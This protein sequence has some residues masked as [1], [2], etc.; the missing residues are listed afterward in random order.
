[1]AY[2]TNS[3][4]MKENKS[5][6]NNEVGAFI[7]DLYNEAQMKVRPQQYSWLLQ[8][9]Y[10]SGDQYKT[11]DSNNFKITELSKAYGYEEREVFNK[12]RTIRNTFLARITLNKPLPWAEPKSLKDKDKKVAK[13]TNAVI[14]NAWETLEIGD[15][16]DTIGEYLTDYGSAFLKVGWDNTLGKKIVSRVDVLLD[17][18]GN[19]NYLNEDYKQKLQQGLLYKKSIYEGDVT[20]SVISPFEIYV[21]NPTRRNL[22]ES[23]W[24]LH[25]RAF[26]KEVVKKVYML[27]DSDI[28]DEITNSITLQT[29]AMSYGIGYYSG[30]YGYKT[31]QLEDVVSVKEYYE[32]PTNDF[33][34]GRM[35]ISVGDKVVYYDELPYNIGRDGKKDIPFIRMIATPETGNFYGA[36]PLADLRPLQRRYNAVRNRAAEA[37]N[38]KAIGQWIAY[39]GSLHS[40]TRITNKPGNVIIVKNGKAAPVRVQDNAQTGEFRAENQD[41]NQEF[42]S[43]SGLNMMSIEGNISSAIRSATQMSMLTEQ[44]D[45]RIRLT[46]KSMAKGIEKWAKFII[47]LYQQYTNGSRF[48]K[49]NDGWEDGIEWDKNL[50]NDKIAIKN[51]SH[52]AIQPAQR[53]Q[54]ILDLTN[55]GLFSEQNAYGVDG[56]KN[57]LEALDL[58]Y[59][60]LD[61][62]IPFK[63][64]LDKV[65]R[66]NRR[67][68]SMQ[69]IVVDDLDNH[70][71]HLKEHRELIIS[72]E[73]E[74]FIRELATQDL[75]KAKQI[76]LMA[77]EH[78]KQHKTQIQVAQMQQNIAMSQ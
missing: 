1:M 61:H 35:I 55:L 73:W 21:D 15:K 38:R 69:A 41:L 9:A 52:L 53:Q 50:I 34:N 8:L 74:D 51:I 32:R 19:S 66:E 44:E 64:D 31:N 49:F 12:M 30:S 22:E 46:T 39:E 45:N 28:K 2:G 7:N 60:E 77:R 78:I 40:Q 72:E 71:I 57:L 24:L 17:E 68:L 75:E 58:K 3:K 4:R 14:Q 59:M 13:I 29:G 25:V 65:K 5:T 10:V 56:T 63:K 18:L 6:T 70:A 76:E 42:Y 33:P 26:P 16:Y 27:E 54:M 43:L 23:P 67:I 48:V 47:R 62:L 37:L 36:T 11:F 20:T